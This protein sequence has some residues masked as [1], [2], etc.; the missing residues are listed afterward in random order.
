MSLKKPHTSLTRNTRVF[1]LC[2]ENAA[3]TKEV[4]LTAG[5]TSGGADAVGFVGLTKIGIAKRKWW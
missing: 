1:F 5:D 2:V 4:D 3:E